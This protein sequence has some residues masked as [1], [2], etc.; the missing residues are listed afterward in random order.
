VTS[1]LWLAAA[2]L[3][4]CACGSAPTVREIHG[5]GNGSL[6]SPST[7]ATASP[8]PAGAKPKLARA[9][10]A[11][12]S[13]SV[14]PSPARVAVSGSTPKASPVPVG[15]VVTSWN[16]PKYG[17]ILV[18]SRGRVLY[19]FTP[20]D[21]T[22]TPTCN[23]SNGCSA[24]WPPF[25]PT[26][27]APRAQGA[28]QQSLLGTNSGQITYNGHPLYFY[29]GDSGADQTNGQCSSNIWY[30]IGVDGNAVMTC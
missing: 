5:Q 24:A 30:V 3:A 20:D 27:G 8:A 21:A 23:S 10:T 4:A 12:P 11:S 16:S 6:P 29:A 22:G 17:Q 28:V 7:A 13:P 19:L 15:T 2:L 26:N 1:R 14:S 18:D 9:S 25:D